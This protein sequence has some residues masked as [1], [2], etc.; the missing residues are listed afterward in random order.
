MNNKILFS[1]FLI[2][3]ILFIV[4]FASR[5]VLEEDI[6][7]ALKDPSDS[8][9]INDVIQNFKFSDKLIVSFS[10]YDTSKQADPE[11][12]TS[13]AENFLDSLTARFDSNYISS[14]NGKVSDS[15]ITF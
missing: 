4:V 14:V 11:K 3:S 6:S 15:L 12:L 10:L 9:R 8:T 7:G 1:L 2:G 5:I 13:F